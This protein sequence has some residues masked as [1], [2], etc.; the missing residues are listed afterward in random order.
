[1]WNCLASTFKT[2]NLIILSQKHRLLV[3]IPAE[4]CAM[5]I[6]EILS[7]VELEEFSVPCL[8]NRGN[9]CRPCDLGP[10][11][12]V[13][14]FHRFFYFQCVLSAIHILYYICYMFS[15]FTVTPTV[16]LAKMYECLL[17]TPNSAKSLSYTTGAE[18]N[19]AQKKNL[20][21]KSIS[22]ICKEFIANNIPN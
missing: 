10:R 7:Y 8:N 1:M 4:G 17:L 19:R 13:P 6:N 5:K 16:Q 3:I 9:L 2:F 12:E 21:W 14:R 15:Q 22:G 18:A 20:F 11:L